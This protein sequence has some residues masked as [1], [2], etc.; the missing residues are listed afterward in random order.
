[1]S[2]VFLYWLTVSLL[3]IPN[4]ISEVNELYDIHLTHTSLALLRLS[5]PNAAQATTITG[6]AADRTIEQIFNRWPDLPERIRNTSASEVSSQEAATV[7]VSAPVDSVISKN[8]AYGRSL[9]Y[10]IWHSDGRLI[11]RSSNAPNEP[12]TQTLGF[13]NTP[14]KD[15]HNWRHYSIWDRSHTLRVVV[16][17]SSDM[18]AQLVRSLAFSAISPIA[19]GLPVLIILLWL[20]IKRGLEPLTELSRSIVARSPDSLTYFHEVNTPW[21]L[22]PIVSAL[23]HLLKRVSRMLQGE[24]RFTDNAAHELR[25]PLA[26]IE[27]HLF[28]A[29]NTADSAEREQ[30]IAQ[31]RMGVGRAIRLVGQ[32]LTLARLEPNQ[33]QP[34]FVPVHLGEMAQS[35]CVDLTPLALARDQTLELV[36]EPNLPAVTGNKD[37]LSMLLSNLVDNA[38]RYTRTGGHITVM[39]KQMEGALLLAVNDDGP[40]IEPAQRERV[41]QR[42]YRLADQRLAGTGLGLT[43]CRS[44]ADLHQATIALSDTQTG[45]GLCVKVSFPQ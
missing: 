29:C 30:S 36:T 37:M 6:D 24:R 13:S 28:A 41:F 9:R 3:G 32:M 15:G 31:A 21:E 35:V 27:A 20:S 43:I 42:F 23:N 44:I 45:Q 1:M 7:P 18:R 19:L 8:I 39:V 22:R 25:T 33:I 40:G 17:E 5:D 34:E 2:V 10:Q 16:S 4:D 14:D 38:I 26:A 11:F 12:I